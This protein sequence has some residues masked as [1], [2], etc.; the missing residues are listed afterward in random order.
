MTREL[1]FCSADESDVELATE[2]EETEEVRPGVCIF[3]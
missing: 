2:T 1:T 3:T